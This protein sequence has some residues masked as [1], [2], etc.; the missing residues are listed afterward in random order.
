MRKLV[1]LLLIIVLVLVAMFFTNT[2]DEN[3]T[4]HLINIS[5]RLSTRYASG[6]QGAADPDT[7]AATIAADLARAKYNSDNFHFYTIY[8]VTSPSS[9]EGIK[10]LG[11]FKMFIKLD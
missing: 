6:T 2:N 5:Q 3:F 4:D 1:V 11:I 9:V 8:K 10:Y 7:S